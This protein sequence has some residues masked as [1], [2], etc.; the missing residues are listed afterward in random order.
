AQIGRLMSFLEEHHLLDDTLIILLSDNGASR[1]GGPQGVM[2]EF[3]F[4]NGEFEDVNEI[5]ATRLDDIGTKNAHSNY[6]WGWSQ[7]GNTPSRWYK[8]Q[9]YG[10]GIRD[11]LI[12][13]WPKRV[14]AAGELRPQF[15][16]IVDIAPTVYEALGIDIPTVVNGHEQ[17]PMHGSSFA[18]TF[19]AAD[20][21]TKRG[22]QYF[23]MVGHRAIWADEWKAVT[24]HDAGV[25]YEND[26]WGL[27]KLNEDFSE[28]HDLA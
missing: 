11:S 15:C 18:Y 8:S 14:T 2:D 12:V 5:V 28:M 10:G 7:V 27:Y 22:P 13:H 17:M 19:T 26:T 16:H 23:E 9:T 1:E 20:G 4:F 24:F 3:S 21:I 25:P 6:P